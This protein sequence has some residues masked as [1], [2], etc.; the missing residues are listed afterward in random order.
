[1]F[2]MFRDPVPGG[3]N[4]ITKKRTIATMTQGTKM[5]HSTTVLA[6]LYYTFDDYWTCSVL[7]KIY[8]NILGGLIPPYLPLNTALNNH[9]ADVPHASAPRAWGADVYDLSRNAYRNNDLQ[10]KMP[11]PATAYYA[12]YIF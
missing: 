5:L 6:G 3:L 1:M 12:I 9:M 2:E 11:H 8:K 4:I 7:V 10:V